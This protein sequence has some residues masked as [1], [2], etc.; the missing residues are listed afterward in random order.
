MPPSLEVPVP[1]PVPSLPTVRVNR[2]RVNV[3]V[4]DRAPLIVTVQVTPETP[5]HPLQP[6]K[7]DPP[8]ALAVS[9]TTAPLSHVPAHVGPQLMPPS[10]ELT[11]P[12]PVPS[13]PTVTV[14]RCRAHVAVTAPASLSRGHRYSGPGVVGAGARGPAVDAAVARGHR[15]AP[16]PVLRDREGEPLDV[17]RTRRSSY[18]AHRHRTGRAGDPIAPT[19]TGEDGA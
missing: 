18:L 16:R 13:L 4:T 17:F 11:A 14:N 5:S 15:A 7:A 12:P 10:L 6:P 8:P 2:C 3:A 19:P 1:L 9:V